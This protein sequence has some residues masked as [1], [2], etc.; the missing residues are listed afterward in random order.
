MLVDCCGCYAINQIIG[1]RGISNV[2]SQ[3]WP[4]WQPRVCASG[5]NA[6][7]IFRVHAQ[8]NPTPLWLVWLAH[9]GNL[10]VPLGT[11]PPLSFPG[12]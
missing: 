2:G 4:R 5:Q 11:Y 9:L 3:L 1:N 10:G 12:R 8:L 6:H 7:S